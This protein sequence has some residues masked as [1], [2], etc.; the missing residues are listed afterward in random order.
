MELATTL[1][2]LVWVEQSLLTKG[3]VMSIA[4]LLLI[5]RDLTLQTTFFRIVLP[6]YTKGISIEFCNIQV[7]IIATPC[8]YFS[9][10]K[11]AF[12]CL[13]GPLMD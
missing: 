13:E 3:N 2:S 11:E 8:F 5:I 9:L 10:E 7:N 6:E 1:T 12:I 4:N